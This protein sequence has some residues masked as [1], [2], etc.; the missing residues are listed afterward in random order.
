MTRAFDHLEPGTA[1]AVWRDTAP[2]QGCPFLDLDVEHVLVLAAHPDDETLG[3]GGLLVAAERVGIAVT[4]AIATDGELSP[5]TPGTGAR[6][7]DESTR[8]VGMLAP[9]ARVVFLG[10][11]DGGLR[12]SRAQLSREI[13]GILPTGE[14]ALIATTWWG[15]GHRDHRILGEVAQGLAGP[16]VRVVGYPIW[17]WHWGEPADVDSLE[18]RIV[19]LDAEA[20][21][22]KAAAI[23]EHRSQ[24]EASAVEP[25]ML[26]DGMRSH[27]LRD[28][29]V[30]IPSEA[31]GWRADTVD[32]AEFDAFI[33]RH[34]D[35]WGFESRWY[36]KRKRA[37]LMA[38][39]P[40]DRVQRVLELGCAT[41]LVTAE[42]AARADAVVAVDG[43]AEAL[44]RAAE[45]VSDPRVEF[46]HGVLPR[47]WP[48]GAFDLIVLSEIAYYLSDADQ[49]RALAQIDAGLTPGGALIACHWRH[50]IDGA[51]SDGDAVHERIARRPGFAR[52]ARY[53][54]VDVVLE[55]FTRPGAP[56]VAAREGLR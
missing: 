47:D 42:L 38:A 17:L 15:D 44:R 6:R 20:L 9:S 54:E 45:R 53:E 3:A 5:N 4:V 29:D 1:E 30:F 11:P 7:R 35:P 37:L 49:D 32:V 22:I 27:F 26:H 21:V 51:P 41:G 13:A 34:D 46:V 56:S 10:L 40:T 48:E 12:E 24:I 55:V 16:R 50:P 33:S 14:R 2:W 19:P 28:V 18:W 23:A 36:E 8:A 31:S 25:A 43:S 52:A 39:L